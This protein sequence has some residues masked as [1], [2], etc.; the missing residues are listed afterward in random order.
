MGM[1]L[2]MG[3]GIWISLVRIKKV[4]VI[5]TLDNLIISFLTTSAGSARGST[6]FPGVA[7]P[8]GVAGCPAEERWGLYAKEEGETTQNL[9]RF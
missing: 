2:Q 6:S 9:E 7:V 8:L 1:F 3:N 5:P 4:Q